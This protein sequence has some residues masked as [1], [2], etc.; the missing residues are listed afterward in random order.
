M[1]SALISWWESTVACFN[2]PDGQRGGTRL[3]SVY[4]D[5]VKGVNAP[6]DTAA[7]CTSEFDGS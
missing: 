6:T 5:G 7:F 1:A 2:W 4:N 3:G